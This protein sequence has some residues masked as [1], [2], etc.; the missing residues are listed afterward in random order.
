MDN[1][2][3]ADLIRITKQRQGVKAL[4]AP[5]LPAPVLAVSSIGTKSSTAASGGGIDSPL[6]ETN[7][8][9]YVTKS[10]DG[11]LSWSVPATMEFADAVGRLVVIEFGQP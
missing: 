5:G 2:A 10:T 11:I 3:K 7:R 6:Q 1:Q 8:T 4:S 9:T